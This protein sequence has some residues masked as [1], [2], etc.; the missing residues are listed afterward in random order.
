MQE[1]FSKKPVNHENKT[2]IVEL[3][4]VITE[5]LIW[6]EQHELDFFEYF[7]YRYFQASDILSLYSDLL[8]NEF[9]KTIPVQLIQ[10]ANLLIHNLQKDSCKDYLLST[11]FYKEITTHPFDFTDE[12]IIGNYMSLLKGLAVNLTNEQLK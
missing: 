9:E 7:L 10:S 3:L 2:E 5:A 12:E 8:Q 1:L 6:S 11:A 4:R